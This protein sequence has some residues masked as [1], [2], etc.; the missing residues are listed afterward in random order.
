M[1]RAPTRLPPLNALRAFEASSRHLNFRLAAKELGV[2]QGAVAQHVRK[3][4][5]ELGLRLFDRLPRSLALTVPGRSYAAQ[6]RRAFELM[7]EATVALRP[8]PDRVTISVTPT[9]AS[10]W[11]LPRLPQF[12]QAH[13]DIELRILA[14]ESLSNF[15]SDGADIAVRQGQPPFGPGLSADLLFEQEVIAV[16][17]PALLPAGDPFL[18]IHSLDAATFLNDAHD[19]WPEFFDRVLA[20]HVPA[21]ARQLRFSQTSLAIDAAAAGQGLAVASRFLVEGELTSRR[22]VQALPGAMRGTMDA[23]VVTLRKPRN[24]RATAHVRQWLLSY[25]PQGADAA[26]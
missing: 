15:Q 18:P 9:F 7:H 17:S 2:T 5:A 4:E 25:R 19:L 11:L 8:E 21:S 26:R 14:T 23:H 13:P 1:G 22:L 20:R 24:P 12:G 10:K 16:C 6:L 3:L